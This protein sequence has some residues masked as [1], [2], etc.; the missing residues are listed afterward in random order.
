M[1]RYSKTFYWVI[2]AASLLQSVAPAHSQVI[3]G[4]K[5]LV[6][7]ERSE[8]QKGQTNFLKTLV[9][10]RSATPTNGG[11]WIDE[12]RIDH[13][14]WTGATNAVAISPAC[15]L[16]DKQRVVFSTN[17]LT[18]V[19]G[20]NQMKV[21][22]VGYFGHLTN[23][24]LIFSND[25]KTVIRQ[26][27]AASSRTNLGLL[28]SAAKPTARTNSEIHITAQRL[29]LDYE[30]NVA[31]YFQD[32]HV[33]NATTDL[34]AEK[35]TIKRNPAGDLENIL[36]ETNVVIR[37]KLEPGWASGDRAL[38]YMRDGEEALMLTGNPAKWNQE[39]RY[40]QAGWITYYMNDRILRAE[41]KAGVRFP[42][43]G[44]TQ[45]DWL[46]GPRR[47]NAPTAEAPQFLEVY[48]E[49]ITSWLATSNR[50]GHRVVA[51]TN[52][53]IMGFPDQMLATAANAQYMEQLGTLE[54]TGDAYWQQGQRI[55]RGERLFYD[56]TNQIFSSDGNS[57]LQVLV[58]EFGR[59]QGATNRTQF[60]QTD[61]AR[62]DYRNGYLTFYEN[63]VSTL[64][65]TNLVRGRLRADDYVRL[66]L[67][68]QVERIT[69]RRNVK[70]EEFSVPTRSGRMNSNVL[71]CEFLTVELNTNGWL[72]RVRAETNVFAQQF[73]RSTNKSS[74][75]SLAAEAVRAD[76]FAHTNDIRE[77]LAERNVVIKSDDSAAKGQRATYT[78]SNHLV[79]LTG[80]P[81]LETPRI[82]FDQADAILYDRATGKFSAR[83]PQGQARAPTNALNQ[84][85]LPGGR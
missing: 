85:R 15:F 48:A 40:G 32:V 67:S 46:P 62:F 9:T 56:R 2:A 44:V 25:V 58:S 7:F 11:Y 83:N 30:R 26:E 45:T 34:R 81:T 55:V 31:V 18:V 60:I 41:D 20:T 22:G 61:S 82:K 3:R 51:Q 71:N 29:H 75:A 38:Y 27:L 12:P 54:L 10:G 43:T 49:A 64:I 17:L 84:T 23:L 68:N 65:E 66:K 5:W 37:Q 52:V 57:Y 8:M 39:E 73:R 53:V 14:L 42:L 21:E 79:E 1:A 78:A 35:L 19:A 6:F 80:E 50:P 33:E 24:F 63:I 28:G 47:T 16:D 76:F 59:Q 72:D 69:A 70:A 13:F 74:H 36:A 4:F 77:L